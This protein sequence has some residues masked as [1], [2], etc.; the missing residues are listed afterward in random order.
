MDFPIWLIGDS[1]PARWEAH[2][3][4]PLDSRHPARHNIWTPILEGIQ[5]HLFSSLR[6]RL[7]TNDLYI[8]NAVHN[9]REKPSG[10]VVEWS[11][12]LEEETRE[13]GRLLAVHSPRLVLSFGAFA[14]EFARRSCDEDPRRAFG[15]WSTERLGQQFRQRIGKFA[16]NEINLVP[17][18]HVSIA[19]RY[20]LESHRKFTQDE[21]GNY[22]EHVAQEIADCLCRN[23][24]AFP[25][26]K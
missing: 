3:D 20:F 25:V 11:P 4:D 19:R 13:L 12:R 15:Y 10:R 7:V 6:S 17:L 23:E 21:N 5:S 18:L 2:L 14:F 16:P 22:F 26:V 1:S 9:A 8:R 24:A